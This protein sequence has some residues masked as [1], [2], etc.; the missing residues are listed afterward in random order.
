MPEEIKE[1][2]LESIAKS[3]TNLTA[4]ID[5]KIDNVNKNIDELAIAVNNEFRAID[6]KFD[7]VNQDIKGLKEGQEEI[8][9]KLDNKTLKLDLDALT[10]RVEAIENK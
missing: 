5:K 6:K 10:T 8:I 3:I 7:A 1:V 2:T 9:M 4:S